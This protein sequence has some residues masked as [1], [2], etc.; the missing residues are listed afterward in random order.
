MPG[1]G[2]MSSRIGQPGRGCCG[3]GR[4]QFAFSAFF[5]VAALCMAGIAVSFHY[6]SEEDPRAKRVAEYDDVVSAW[7][8]TH[9]AAYASKWQGASST[10]NF[11][12]TRGTTDD[13][14]PVAGTF[15]ENTSGGLGLDTSSQTALGQYGADVGKYSQGMIVKA[16]L[17]GFHTNPYKTEDEFQITLGSIAGGDVRTVRA[18]AYRCEVADYQGGTT[19]KKQTMYHAVPM[20]LEQVTL[21]EKSNDADEG[22]ETTLPA[23]PYRWAKK[24]ATPAAHLNN[25]KA[26]KADCDAIGRIPLVNA[27]VEI[28]IRSPNDPYIAAATIAAKYGGAGGEPGCARDFGPTQAELRTERDSNA[29]TSAVALFLAFILYLNGKNAAKAAMEA[30]GGGTGADAGVQMRQS[31]PM[32]G[33]N[34][35]RHGQYPAPAPAPAQAQ[36]GG[37]YYAPFGQAQPQPGYP[38]PPPIYTATIEPHQQKPHY[39]PV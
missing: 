10:P 26:A 11:T 31:P 21:V 25:Y 37:G 15:D 4:C 20:H 9:R 22:V 12:I 28:V 8:G 36:A 5:L 30:A 19:K 33:S 34:V 24:L 6:E 38:T 35:H 23:C 13:P 1:R 7:T 32:F 16:K 39:P 3:A 17:Q 27:D 29:G 14:S 2:L 18:K